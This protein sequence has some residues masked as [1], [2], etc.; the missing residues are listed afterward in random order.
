MAPTML[1]SL[2][3]IGTSGPSLASAMTSFGGARIRQVWKLGRRGEDLPLPVDKV[4]N[5]KRLHGGL[6]VEEAA[7]V[8]RQRPRQL[9]RLVDVPRHGDGIGA[10]DLV[11]FLEIGAWRRRSSSAMIDLVR[12]ENQ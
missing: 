12:S 8:L 3:E 2:R 10:D 11:M 9:H 5:G 6:G 1:V 4:G 7:E